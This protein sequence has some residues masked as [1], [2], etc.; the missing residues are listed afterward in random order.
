MRISDWSS[1][2]CSSDLFSDETPTEGAPNGTRIMRGAGATAFID[3]KLL[4]MSIGAAIDLFEQDGAVTTL[5]QPSLTALSGETAS[6]LACGEFHITIQQ[7][8]STRLNSSHSC[9]FRMPP[10]ACKQKIT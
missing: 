6:F 9:A 7:R 8:E 4:G 5:A 3:K 10:H 1:D 2:V